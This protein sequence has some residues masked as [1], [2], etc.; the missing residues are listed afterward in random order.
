MP[1]EPSEDDKSAYWTP[2]LYYQ[3]SNGTF[4]EVPNSGLT[5]YYEGRGD[6]R[7]LQPFPAGF[8]MVS[9][10]LAAR[11]YNKQALIPGSDRPIADRVSFA[12]LNG[13][14]HKEQPVMDNTDCK[15]GLRAQIHFQSCWNGKDLYKPDNSHVEYMS[16][17]D[18]GKCPSTHPVPFV[19]LFYE[20]LYGVNDIKKDGGKF[21]FSQGD[22]TG[23]G[24]HGDFL[25]GWKT[26]VLTDALKQCAYTVGG[27]VADCAPFKPSLDTSFAT[28][29]PEVPSVL[30][31]PVHG[32]IDKLTGCIK[33]TSGPQ[34]ATAADM[35]C[36]A[37]GAT[38][39]KVAQSPQAAV[40]DDD[41]ADTSKQRRYLPNEESQDDV[42]GDEYDPYPYSFDF[43]PTV[44]TRHPD[45]PLGSP[46]P[47]RHKKRA[48]APKYIPEGEYGSY[49]FDYPPTVTSNQPWIPNGSPAPRHRESKRRVPLRKLKTSS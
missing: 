14:S 16:G 7:N 49:T 33:I 47:N 25:N 28:N 11:S 44:T 5:V 40:D 2:F 18:N 24:F 31:E 20:V 27:D 43:P 22:T 12:C 3:H 37:G 4:E 30:N 13:T 42:Q 21:V 45:V 1:R 17:L 6:D 38:S 39:S 26:N 48:I 10:N 9:G 8:R 41:E 19:H 23:Y 35:T 32:L 29:C 34:D 15:D 36:P 46:T